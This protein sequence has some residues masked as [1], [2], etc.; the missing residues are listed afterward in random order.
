MILIHFEGPKL[1]RVQ[2]QTSPWKVIL[3]SCQPSN[4]HVE[5]TEVRVTVFPIYGTAIAGNNVNNEEVVMVLPWTQYYIAASIAGNGLVLLR[6]SILRMNGMWGQYY[7]RTAQIPTSCSSSSSL[8]FKEKNKF[9]LVLSSYPFQVILL[10][11]YPKKQETLI[12]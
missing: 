10:R 8:V 6:F 2:A 3:G 11:K 9:Y 4:F 7:L 1:S 5:W 12:I